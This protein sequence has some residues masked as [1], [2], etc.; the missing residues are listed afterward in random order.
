MNDFL[1][2]AFAPL[3]VCGFALASLAA[4]DVKIDAR[5]N[6]LKAD[7]GNYFNWTLGSAI[8]DK[9]DA[10][11]GAS[12]AGST[13]AFN[14]VRYDANDTKKAAIPVGLRG[15]VL[16]SVSDFKTLTDDAL[17]VQANGKALTVRY[18]HYGYA[19]ELSTDSNGKFDVLKGAK[20]AKDFASNVGGEFVIKKGFVKAGGDPKK[21]SDL[22]WS[23]LSFVP[24]VKDPKAKRWYVGSLDFALNGGVFTVKG[25]LSEK[26]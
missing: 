4:Q 16:Y 25:T 12:L 23:K 24:D 21:M 3:V 5:M 18:V 8:S 11:S 1:R 10:T 20:Y 26:K 17:A 13:G 2:R 6:T 14:K 22:D 7:S 19:F 15:L 9:Y